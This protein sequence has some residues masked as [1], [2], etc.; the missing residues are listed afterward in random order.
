MAQMT[1]YQDYS[2]LFDEGEADQ[3][4]TR[5]ADYVPVHRAISQAL[6]DDETLAV[7]IEHSARV[8]QA[9]L[10]RMAEQ[11]NEGHVDR[12]L[13]R[14]YRRRL[15]DGAREAKSAGERWRAGGGS[16]GLHGVGPLQPR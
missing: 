13:R 2:D 12:L 7:S 10:R 9:W 14:I 16:Q 3:Q 6:Q 11:R 1:I 4:I 5:I 15:D 8:C